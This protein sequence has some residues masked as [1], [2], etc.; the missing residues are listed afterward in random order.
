MK[1][2]DLIRIAASGYPDAQVLEYWD[3]DGA[4]PRSNP[5]GGDTLARFVALELAETFDDEAPTSDQAAEAVRAM[6]RASKDL[7]HVI[8]AIERMLAEGGEA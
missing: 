4:K 2:N 7:Q 8:H 3:F 5:D 1:L 6:N